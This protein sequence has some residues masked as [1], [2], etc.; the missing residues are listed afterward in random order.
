[1]EQITYKGEVIAVIVRAKHH[2][3]N[4]EFLSQEDDPLQVGLLRR[5][6]KQSA[7]AHRRSYKPQTVSVM[8]QVIYVIQGELRLTLYDEK[9]ELAILELNMSDGDIALLKKHAHGVDF[10]AETLILEVKQGPYPG[11]KDAKI[12][13]KKPSNRPS[14]ARKIIV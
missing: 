1:M 12:L 5:H 3:D 7:A 9:T 8:Q 6:A 2:V 14:A 11:V 4:V 10:L 13:L